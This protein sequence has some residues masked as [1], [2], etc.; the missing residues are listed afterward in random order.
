VAGGA[1][2]G[3]LWVS[4]WDVRGVRAGSAAGWASSSDVDSDSGSADASVNPGFGAEGLDCAWTG[5]EIAGT[6]RS[7]PAARWSG[8]LWIVGAVRV[9]RAVRRGAWL[10]IGSMLTGIDPGC[11]TSA[12]SRAGDG[13]PVCVGGM[14]S[15]AVIGGGASLK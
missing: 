4:G 3:V 13:S 7:T 2:A 8:T 6:A 11:R 12:G 15:G 14:G 5:R 9:A 1:A 10:G